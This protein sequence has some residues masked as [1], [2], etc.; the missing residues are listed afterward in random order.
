MKFKETISME[1]R[2]Q[3]V[4][5]TCYQQPEYI[6]DLMSCHGITSEEE[7]SIF[8]IETFSIILVYIDPH[9]LSAS[10]H[11]ISEIL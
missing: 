3:M 11:L 6:R 1:E 8:P 5:C 2:H 9:C 7:E 10:L 4:L